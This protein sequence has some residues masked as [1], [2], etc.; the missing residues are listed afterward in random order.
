MYGN[1]TFSF[2]CKLIFIERDLVIFKNIF[3]ASLYKC[4]GVK[5]FHIITNI[6]TD[7]VLYHEPPPC[8]E[9]SLIV[10]DMYL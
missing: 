8:T 4:I 1:V 3:Y 7:G 5:Y 2:N 9:T 6:K 10:N